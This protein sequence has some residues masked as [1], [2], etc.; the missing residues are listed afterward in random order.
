MIQHIVF[1]HATSNYDAIAH[2]TRH[3]SAALQHNGTTCTI[4]NL[5]HTP[6]P[7]VI[8]YI[9]THRPGYTFSFNPI[10][11]L[12]DGRQFCDVLETPHIT[13]LLDILP[14]H[15]FLTESPYAIVA[16]VDNYVCTHLKQQNFD[17]TF[18]FPLGI[19]HDLTSKEK[20]YDITFVGTCIDY[21]EISAHWQNTY[22]SD[23]R[24]RI[25]AIIDATINDTHTSYLQHAQLLLHDRNDID[26]NTICSEILRYLKGYER[27]LLLNSL[28]GLPIHIFGNSL[29]PKTWDDFLPQNHSFTIHDGVP[30]QKS[31]EITAQSRVI[32]NSSPGFKE[33]PH[34]RI[35]SG[36]ACEALVVTND[37]TY[38]QQ[39]IPTNLGLITFTHSTLNALKDQ[40][41]Y[42]IAH[43]HQ[44]TSITQHGCSYAINNHTWSSRVKET[45]L[46]KYID[47]IIE[48]T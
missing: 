30:Y 48:V 42:H 32:I 40:L 21:D 31:L 4:F 18:F 33:G 43:P 13:V 14:E 19:P 35:L 17:K 46:L 47:N 20:C 2:F 11:P 37:T 44:L 16:S 5:Y 23:L 29:G 45:V 15:F 38:I 34:D 41:A 24:S 9:E 3:F 6:I 26:F 25:D 28:N 7:H 10:M 12:S 8:D 1:F 22:D 39:N 36:L 27:I